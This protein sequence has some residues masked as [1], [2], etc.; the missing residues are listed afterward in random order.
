MTAVKMTLQSGGILLVPP[1]CCHSSCRP[2]RRSF[3]DASWPHLSHSSVLPRE[4]CSISINPLSD[5]AT[6]VRFWSVRPIAPATM[7]KAFV[8]NT[9]VHRTKVIPMT[10]SPVWDE[11]FFISPETSTEDATAD[12]DGTGVR[13]EIWDHDLHGEGD[14]LGA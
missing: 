12:A 2:G 5:P 13:F 7:C 10:L 8:G 1:G 14:Y 11:A 6:G 3:S 4:L 9:E